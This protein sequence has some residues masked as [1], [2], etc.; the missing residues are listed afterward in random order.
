LK[1]GE[2]IA[3][4][5]LEVLVSLYIGKLSKLNSDIVAP[6]LT[7]LGIDWADAGLDK[8]AQNI[9]EIDCLNVASVALFTRHARELEGLPPTQEGIDR[10]TFK[11]LPWFMYSVWLPIRFQPP[12][13]P[14][15]DASGFPVFLGSCHGLLADLENVK[16]MSKWRLGAMPEGYESMRRDVIEF[17]KMVFASK[18]FRVRGGDEAVAQW[19]WRAL[20]D[21]ATLGIEV[22]APVFGACD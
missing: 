8:R 1:G 18:G 15:T 13:K 16:K 11:N 9:V 19:V 2:M 5:F 22:N 14:P 21:A 20:F 6:V 10:S 3:P 4:R 17:N 7:R 12:T